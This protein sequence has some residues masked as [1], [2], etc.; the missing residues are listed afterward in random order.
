MRGVNYLC[1]IH[2]CFLWTHGLDLPH[3]PD[4]TY[5]PATEWIFEAPAAAV[6]GIAVRWN[7]SHEEAC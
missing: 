5:S 6:L 3:N 1:R 4:Q 2:F 7:F